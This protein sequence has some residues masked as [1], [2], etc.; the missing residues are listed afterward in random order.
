VP[1]GALTA[2][3]CGERGKPEV[4]MTLITFFT[5]EPGLALVAEVL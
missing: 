3:R 4:S 1:V 5:G 2:G